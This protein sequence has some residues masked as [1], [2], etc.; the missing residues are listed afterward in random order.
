M[1]NIQTHPAIMHLITKIGNILN[2]QKVIKNLGIGVDIEKV[3]RFRK[4]SLITHRQF[5]KKIFT[6]RELKYCFSK[7]D[8]STH[9]AAR[10]CGKEAVIKAVAG[11]KIHKITYNEIEII[12]NLKGVP[13]TKLPKK[14]KG[15]EI[16]ISL[17]HTSDYA[18]AY[19][20]AYKLK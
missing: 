12:N 11:L 19:V 9:L 14:Y 8:P 15:I 6:A 17:S 2:M 5:L 16:K 4:L 10:F 1:S 13:E 3:E 20:V 18:I 7:K